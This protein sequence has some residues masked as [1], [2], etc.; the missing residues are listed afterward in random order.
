MGELLRRLS[1]PNLCS[2]LDWDQLVRIWRGASFSSIVKGGHTICFSSSTLERKKIR[3]VAEKE[4][5]VFLCFLS[6]QERKLFVIRSI[7]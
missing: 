1:S 3:R 2:E 5:F 7:L 6:Y 4:T